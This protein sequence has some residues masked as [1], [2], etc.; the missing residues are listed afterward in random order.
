MEDR[1]SRDSQG[2]A[3]FIE[4]FSPGDFFVTMGRTVTETDLVNY[5]GLSGFF[6]E[7]FMNAPMAQS[8]SVY[9]RRV[10]PG[11]LVL[12][13]AEGLFVL[14]GRL[15]QGIAFLGLSDLQI[16]GPVAVGDTLSARL[17]V[18]STRLTSKPGRGILEISHAVRA[19]GSVVME[20]TSARMVAARGT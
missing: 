3:W 19:D 13:I 8:R 18:R 1:N 12:A 2:P 7:V 6:E 4:D 9:Q 17:E 16:R 5:L 11:V 14:T 20:Y 15:Q 10:V